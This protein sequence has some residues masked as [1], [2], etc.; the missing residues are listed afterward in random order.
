MPNDCPT[1]WSTGI[2]VAGG[3]SSDSSDVE[4]IG[5]AFGFLFLGMCAGSSCKVGLKPSRL[6]EPR[7]HR[8]TEESTTGVAFLRDPFLDGAGERK[9]KSSEE[10]AGLIGVTSCTESEAEAGSDS[11]GPGV[12]A[13]KAT[14]QDHLGIR[15]GS[16]SGIWNWRG[17]CIA[18]AGPIRFSKERVQDI[19]G[20]KGGPYKTLGTSTV[21]LD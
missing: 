12:S 19:S 8:L 4:G 9:D 21:M 7:V 14:S 3:T 10:E 13:S 17:I 1:S 11:E 15:M 18:A 2:G 5:L 6:I 16:R 20:G